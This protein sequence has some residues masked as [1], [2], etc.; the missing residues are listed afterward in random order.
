MHKTVRAII[1]LGGPWTGPVRF[2][3]IFGP[4]TPV[5]ASPTHFL[6]LAS[7]CRPYT[8]VVRAAVIYRPRFVLWLSNLEIILVILCDRGRSQTT[9]KT[10][11]SSHAA[12]TLDVLRLLPCQHVPVRYSVLYAAVK[13]LVIGIF[14]RQ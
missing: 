4:V 1:N 9:G 2:V 11:S 12:D 7:V 13:L 10:R 14:G 6:V 5:P 3:I 8:Y